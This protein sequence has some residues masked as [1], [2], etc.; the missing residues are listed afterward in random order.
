MIRLPAEW[1]LQSAILLTWPHASTPWLQQHEEAE[2][3]WLAIA[4]A[5]LRDQN[6]IISCEDPAQLH[7][8]AD[9]LQPYAQAHGS[10][11]SLYQVPANDVWTRDHGPISIEENGH[12][13]LLDFQFNAWG[14]KYAF[15]KDD[16]IPQQLHACGA[17]GDTPLRRVKLVLEGGSIDSDGQGSLL[18][19]E[20]CLLSQAR[21]PGLS[22][23]DIER[24]LQRALGVERVLWL[25]HGELQGD[26]TDGHIDTLAR[27][28]DAETICHV[29]CLDE[30]DPH[31]ASLLAMER[32]LRQLVNHRGQSYRL[33][34]LP[35][36]DAII[37]N[38]RRLAATYANFLIT[39][40]AVLVPVYDVP[41]DRVALARIAQCFPGREVRPINCRTLIRNNGSLHC[42]TMQI[43]HGATS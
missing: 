36:P 1:E 9:R 33:V 43:H 2:Q 7:R 14:H 10:T 18:T 42:V 24:H 39:N 30:R 41:Q 12:P 20:H 4:H 31:H 25:S 3:T 8:L 28:C 11:L 21:N 13:V 17:F 19:T 35:M 22:K 32:E 15:D 27:F 16:R 40:H 23:H 37:E 38:G 34:P 5:V 29:Q 6:L 26:D